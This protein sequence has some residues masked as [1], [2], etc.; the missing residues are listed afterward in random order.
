MTKKLLVSLLAVCLLAHT[1]GC[2]SG[3]VQEESDV[4][5]ADDEGFAEEG[6]SDY[7]DGEEGSGDDSATID[8]EDGAEVAEE[9]GE[10]GSEEV[11]DAEMEDGEEGGEVADAEMEDGEEGG[12][13]A[14]GTEAMGEEEDLAMED[15]DEDSEFPEDVA[16]ETAVADTGSQP[17]DESLFT[18]NNNETTEPMPEPEIPAVPADDLFKNSAPV[19]A[20][21]VAYA[22]LQKIKDAPFDRGGALLNRVYL[23]RKGD[24]LKAVSQKIYGS[25]RASDLRKWN[26][27]VRN[28]PRVGEKIYY[29]SPRDPQDSSRMLTF[30]EDMEVAPQIHV[31]RDGDNIRELGASL[32]GN[33]E[34]WKEL[35]STNLDVASKGDLPAGIELRYWP[36]SAVAA[37]PPPLAQNPSPMDPTAM[38]GTDPMDPTMAQNQMPPADPMQEPMPEPAPSEMPMDPTMAQNQP[39]DPTMQPPADPGQMSPPPATGQIEPPANPLDADPVKKKAPA[40]ADLASSEDTTMLLMVAGVALLLLVGVFIIMRKNRARQIDLSQTQ[41]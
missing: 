7:A 5:A 4:A 39:T 38:G 19:A 1:V 2:T 30:Y 15:G 6:E 17:S 33:G 29:S 41:V 16:D 32:L 13:V 3:D 14:D 35:W 34:S 23:A 20:A 40:T 25:D 18:A 21:P 11:A 10:A 37:A 24:T 12:E 8:E 36:E 27:G 26:P 28:S 22:P 9:E 31:T